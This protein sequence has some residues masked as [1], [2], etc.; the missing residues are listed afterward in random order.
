MANNKLILR[1]IKSPWVTPTPDVTKGSVLTHDELDSNQ[2]YLRGELIY[3]ASES[4][5]TVTLH[6]INGNNI[7]FNAGNV[8]SG[9][10]ALD[11]GNGTGWRLI[12][13]NPA[14]YGNIGTGAIDFS[15]SSSTSST[16]GSTGTRSITFGVNNIN[17]YVDTIMF[18]TSAVG[19]STNG[20]SGYNI[21]GGEL[22][23]Y[24]NNIYNSFGNGFKSNMGTSGAI[25]SGAVVYESIMVGHWC[26]LYAG[27]SSAM[28]G[29]ALS[30]GSVGTT[31]VGVANDDL[32]TSIA[33][34]ITNDFNAYGPRFIVGTGNVNPDS[35]VVS[36][37]SNGFV[38][39]SDGT[40]SFPSLSNA[41]IDS[42]GDDSAVTKGWVNFNFSGGTS[43][44]TITLSGGTG[45]NIS[46][47]SPTV[48]SFTGATPSGLEKITETNTG[49]RLIGKNPANY[50]NIAIDISH[51]T[52][53]SSTKGST[54]EY[55]FTMGLNNEN[56]WGKT[57]VNGLD[58]IDVSSGATNFSHVNIIN[59][60]EF[61]IGN[62][63]IGNAIFGERSTISAPNTNYNSQC[64]FLSLHQ[65]GHNDLYAGHGSA[66]IGNLLINGAPVCTVV[67]AANLDVTMTKA[68][69]TDE[70][71]GGDTNNPRFI[72]GCGIVSDYE[73][74]TA[75]LRAN[76]FVV[77]GD[78]GVYA[79]MMTNNFISGATSDVLITKAYG[80]A[81]YGT[82]GATGGDVYKVGTPVNNQLGVWT[83]DGTLEGISGITYGAIAGELLFD[84][85]SYIAFG[86]T[87]YA[88]DGGFSLDDTGISINIFSGGIDV[89]TSYLETSGSTMTPTRMGLVNMPTGGG[90]DEVASVT[91]ETNKIVNKLSSTLTLDYGGTFLFPV[92]SGDSTTENTIATQEWVNFNFTGA[93]NT[94]IITGATFNSTTSVLELEDTTDSSNVTVLLTGTTIV[95]GGGDIGVTG[96]GTTGD[97]YIVA[98]KAEVAVPVLRYVKITL[99]S[100]DT[101]NI[102]STPITA[103]VAPGANKAIEV[104]TAAVRLR[105]SGVTF[106]G[107]SELEVACSTA[108]A[109]QSQYRVDNTL[110]SQ[111]ANNFI[112][113]QRKVSTAS[114]QIIENDSLVIRG[115]ANSTVG[116][117]EVDVYITYRIIDL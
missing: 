77:W 62:S 21:L 115:T 76:G 38:V 27:R 20:L 50:G 105:Y 13:R 5:S 29:A 24:Y 26:N 88:Y 108:G 86:T 39:M 7:I 33:N 22:V 68:K 69:N 90:F 45:I 94:Q 42:S 46:G 36:S 59:G 37:R 101:Q 114:P 23:N 10:E 99:T 75:S 106:D 53:A 31:I 80:D 117:S 18:G 64:T 78:G 30:G 11:E 113:M 95:E 93:T 52:T 43:G 41:E 91:I 14:N 49:W 55:S 58:N 47:S 82:T 66:M 73:T 98:Y 9:L 4:G 71:R 60:A 92:L 103:V 65:G 111:T 104:F 112:S 89:K 32:T 109:S 85:A 54:G 74:A 100:G 2:V 83:G 28:F 87:T 19:A 116:N 6:K 44:G 102:F 56:P 81:N 40:A 61:Q 17:P 35:G 25:L 34:Y 48:V 8:N 72:V 97:P 107:T 51:S 110:L 12:G 15:E 16:R 84:N 1:S 63:I 96:N 79:P 67:G 70:G 57:F 3:G